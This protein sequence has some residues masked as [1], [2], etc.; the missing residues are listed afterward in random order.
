VLARR[1]GNRWYIAGINAEKEE[2]KINIDLAPFK[3]G[4]GRLITDT[5]GEGL[6]RG[7]PLFTSARMAVKIKPNGGFIAILE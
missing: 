5:D 6:F 4:S 2:K 3:K 1:S 7:V